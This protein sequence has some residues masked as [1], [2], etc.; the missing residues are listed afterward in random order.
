MLRIIKE[1]IGYV[2]L[3][4]P[5]KSQRIIKTSLNPS[6]LLK[7]GATYMEGHLYDLDHKE[8]VAYT[9]QCTIKVS[10]ERPELEGVSGFV[11]QF[12]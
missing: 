6:I 11:N 4:F 10:T 5:D 12:I 1:G 9:L 3:T 7:N 2:I 8:Q